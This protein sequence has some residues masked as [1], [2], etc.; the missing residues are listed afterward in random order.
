MRLTD[1]SSSWNV[2]RKALEPGVLKKMRL[3]REVGKG[4]RVFIPSCHFLSRR[5]DVTRVLRVSWRHR[6]VE[7]QQGMHT[8][9]KARGALRF[10]EDSPD[11]SSGDCGLLWLQAAAKH[12]WELVLPEHHWGFS[13]KLKGFHRGHERIENGRSGASFVMWKGEHS[14]V[15]S[16]IHVGWY[17]Y[18]PGLGTLQALSCE[19]AMEGLSPQEPR[20]CWA[21]HG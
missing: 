10:R 5:V 6:G 13:F 9:Q 18:S 19:L 7:E 16:E 8:L 12:G 20:I 14:N 17:H 2:F 1:F 21:A 15:Q 11:L 3:C 4:R